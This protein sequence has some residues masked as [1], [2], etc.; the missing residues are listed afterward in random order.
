MQKSLFI[1]LSVG[2]LVGANSAADS[3]PSVSQVLRVIIERA[4]DRMKRTLLLGVGDEIV[5]RSRTFSDLVRQLREAQRVLLYL[6]FTP[7]GAPLPSGRT[8]FE[9]APSGLVVGFIEIDTVLTHPRLRDGA[10]V[11]HELAHA[12]EVSCLPH[13]HSTEELRQALRAR[14]AS[15]SNSRFI[16]T[17]FAAAVEDAVLDEWFHDDR[18]TS[19]LP[20]LVAKYDLDGC[21]LP[22]KGDAT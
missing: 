18:I 4:D 13:L 22:A 7:L 16:E 9:I 15:E 20:A 12:F 3:A 11:V 14:A 2:L 6:R 17:P 5:K 19:Q 8:H 10:I 21:V 1:V